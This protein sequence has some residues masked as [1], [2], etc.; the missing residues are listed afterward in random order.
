MFN[1]EGEMT[2]DQAR[3]TAVKTAYIY[4]LFQFAINT[5]L[6]R[7]RRDNGYAKGLH[8]T[9]REFRTAQAFVR[10]RFRFACWFTFRILTGICPGR[11]DSD[12]LRPPRRFT[13]R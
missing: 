10:M 1:E 13:D 12:R 9:V 8:W 3:L 5:V 2:W 6:P 4:G 7:S 11:M